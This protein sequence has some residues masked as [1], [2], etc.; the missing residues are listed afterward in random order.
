MKN[1][2]EPQEFNGMPLL[3]FKYDSIYLLMLGT[4]LLIIC[5]IS[6][7]FILFS[8]AMNLKT[9]LGNFL[10]MVTTDGFL[11]P[12]L[13]AMPALI[14]IGVDATAAFFIIKLLYDKDRNMTL[15]KILFIMA[16]LCG[17]TAIFGLIFSIVALAHSHSAHEQLHDSIRDSMDNY[18]LD[19][20]VKKKLD[21]MQITFQCCGSKTY[22]EWYEI[23]WFDANFIDNR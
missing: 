1:P 8:I 19:T 14:V 21:M 9:N 16:I 15:N 7:S 23:R 12:L 5:S 22:T 4:I 10:T 2:E 11:L 18:A 6:Y 13:I 17:V 20:K 3:T